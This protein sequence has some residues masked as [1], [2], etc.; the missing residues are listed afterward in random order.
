M[1]DLKIYKVCDPATLF[2]AGSRV[3]ESRTVRLSEEQARYDVM[4]GVLEL[5]EAPVERAS[6]P[7][8]SAIEG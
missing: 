1:S 4:A 2:I 8:R 7:A 5:V 6:K 3:D